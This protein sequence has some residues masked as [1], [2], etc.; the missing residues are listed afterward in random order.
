MK[1]TK[2]QI[3]QVLARTDATETV[4]FA[5]DMDE[6][7]FENWMR[8]VLRLAMVGIAVESLPSDLRSTVNDALATAAGDV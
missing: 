4:A 8:E 7:D 6:G 1:V 5:R 3:E 2:E